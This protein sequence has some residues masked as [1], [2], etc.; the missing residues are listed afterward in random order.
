[1]R[2][3]NMFSAKKLMLLL[4]AGTISLAGCK[5]YLDVN[6]NPN[7][8]DSATPALLLPTV[9]ASVGQL[10]GNSFQV[11]GGI[12]A[13]FWTQSPTA[14][15]YRT[16]DQ[17][18]PAN[19]TY[20]RPW[21][22]IYRSA[23]INA[24]LIINNPVNSPYAKGMAYVLK[25]YTFQVATDAFGDIPLGEALKGNQYTSPKYA[26]Q[27]LVYDSV[28][29]Y[30][31]KGI[32]LLNTATAPAIGA[33]DMI[34]QGNTTKWKAFANTLKL[35]AYL[36]LSQVNASKAQ[37]GIAAIYAANPAFLAEDASIK[38]TTTGGNQNPLYNEMVALSR[39]Q[40]LV[41]SGTTVKAFKA[42]NDPRAFK[43]YNFVSGGSTDTIAYINQGTYASNST[44]R[45]ST[46]SALVG[47]V[48]VDDASAVAPVKLM[49]TSESAFL[50]AEAVAR[51]WASGSV[52]ALFTSG[53]TSSFTSVGLTAAQATAYLAA[54][55]A[56]QLTTDPADQI[57]KIITQKYF[58]MC[59]FQGFE[60]W[61]EW[62]RTGYPDF[63]VRSAASVLGAN[64]RVAL[65]MLYPNSEITTNANY[66]GTQL[67]YT[68]VW[69]DK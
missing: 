17:Y 24:E 11:N 55:P 15:Q 25:A 67:I 39:T 21:L 32:A 16:L 10:I 35:K 58:S 60:A 59:G 49:S 43:F 36:R 41:A 68:P 8:P 53:V 2:N 12:W 9:E 69:W 20:D 45:V 26:T 19:T 29:T 50:Q 61:T 18:N 3:Q 56:A 30:I 14:S 4:L 38:Y 6:D 65:R 63:L 46:P 42:N 51:G 54:A 7:N 62:R 1:M 40:N 34:F 57:K 31:D 44:K 27:E 33:Q 52:T 66:P 22:T 5:K 48:A 64:T 28:F 23:L 13:Q 37:A 47:G